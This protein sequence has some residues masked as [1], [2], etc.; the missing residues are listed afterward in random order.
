MVTKSLQRTM[1]DSVARAWCPLGHW[2]V[3]EKEMLTVL[4]SPRAQSF[5]LPVWMTN[6]PP[7]QHRERAK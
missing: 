5:K 3:A 6:P 7:T 4:V 2:G 1:W